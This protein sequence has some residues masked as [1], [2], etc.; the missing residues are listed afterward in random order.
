MKPQPKSPEWY[1]QQ[2]KLLK[3]FNDPHYGNTSPKN[4][5]CPECGR[6][7]APELPSDVMFGKLP[8]NPDPLPEH[9]EE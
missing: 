3:Q 2:A 6:R 9:H 5:V 8:N 1:E 4:P 7:H